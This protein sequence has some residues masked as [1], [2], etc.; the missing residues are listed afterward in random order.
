[1]IGG[2]RLKLEEKKTTNQKAKSLVEKSK[3]ILK[4]IFVSE[5]FILYLSLAYFFILVPFVPGLASVPN[6]MNL[7]S[8]MW[9]MLT[10]AIGQTMVLIVAGI[11]LSQTATLGITS[12]IGA[13]VMS[14]GID[15]A[16]LETSPLWGW[17]ITEQGGVLAGTR[18]AIPVGI[19]IMLAV[20]T[21]IGWFNGIAI[22]K[23][24]ITAFMVTLVS[25][26]FFGALAIYLS[27]SQNIMN[28]PKAF[29]SIGTE[30]IGIIPFSLVIAVVLGIVAHIILSSTV[31]GRWLYSTGTNIKSS[32]VSGVPTDKV[33]IFAYMFSGFCTSVGAIL[34]SARL[35]MGR[36]TLGD[37]MLMDIIGATVIGGTSMFGGK[38]KVL[39]TVF[40][41]FFFVLLSN[42]LNLLN[43]SYFTINIVKGAI[44]VIAAFIDVTRTR[45]IAKGL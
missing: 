41:V 30:G 34:Y 10:I 6:I 40:G 38:G 24:K 14:T 18:M 44:I 1:M 36:P 33:V 7:F 21:L 28:L 9:P 35:G 26:M 5:Y 25:Q 39:W 32:I 20:G 13:M 31:L 4:K 43:L 42:T 23:F 45:I 2:I 12:I 3:Y 17:F 15:P 29:S 11:D 27:T 16:L 8:N 37:N 22:A 19:V